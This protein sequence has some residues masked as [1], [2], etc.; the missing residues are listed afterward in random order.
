[1]TV[2]FDYEYRFVGPIMN[3]LFGGSLGTSRLTVSEHH[4]DGK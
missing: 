2:E 4:A 3:T 1:M